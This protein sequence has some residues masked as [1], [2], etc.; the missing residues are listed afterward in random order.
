MEQIIDKYI[1]QIKQNVKNEIE[2]EF[3]IVFL[4]HY[5]K[6]DILV[7]INQLKI[8]NEN[9]ENKLNK[10]I[11]D[12]NNVNIN[13]IK[14]CCYCLKINNNIFKCEECDNRFC[15]DNQCGYTYS[16]DTGNFDV[17]LCKCCFK[18]YFGKKDEQKKE[19]EHKFILLDIIKIILLK[20]D[21]IKQINK[22]L[23]DNINICYLEAKSNNLNICSNKECNKIDTYFAFMNCYKC[24]KS[25]CLDHDNK[26]WKKIPYSASCSAPFR[27]IC[28]DC[29]N[30]N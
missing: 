24:G 15:D 3:L 21:H 1:K 11:N 19:K 4:T 25:S 30:E 20:Y 7:Q 5:I 27:Y 16:S 18:K 2:Y 17:I 12:I 13:N 8:L 26:N 9:L 10:M 29:D 22:K 14:K 28:P 23:N 6:C